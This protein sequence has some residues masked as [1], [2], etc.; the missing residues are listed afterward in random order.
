MQS[1]D[2]HADSWSLLN[3]A[4][5]E[6]TRRLFELHKDYVYRLALSRMGSVSDA[7]DVTQDVFLRLL[8]IRKK[9]LRRAK[10][11]TWLYRVTSNV[12][13]DQLRRTKRLSFFAETPQVEQADR[14]ET[15]L[16]LEQ[17]LALINRLPTRQREV[18]LLREFEGFSTAETADLLDISEGAVKSHLHRG[19]NHLRVRLEPT[20][21]NLSNS[22]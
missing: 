6:S 1:N 20:V 18:V 2:P 19:L 8:S 4:T 5:P 21:V 7:E 12:L 13:T 16:S 3:Q 14:A 11:R 10:F 15:N 22:N 9:H 17:A